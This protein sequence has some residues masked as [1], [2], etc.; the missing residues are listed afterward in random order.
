MKGVDTGHNHWE[1]ELKLGQLDRESAVIVGINFDEKGEGKH[2][3]EQLS[4]EVL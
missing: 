3:F 2:I 1:G 4:P